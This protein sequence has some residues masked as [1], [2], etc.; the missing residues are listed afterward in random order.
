MT[1]KHPTQKQAKD[2]AAALSEVLSDLE[3][4]GQ[5]IP[6]RVRLAL[7]YAQEA[8]RAKYPARRSQLMGAALVHLSPSAAR[9]LLESEGQA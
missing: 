5:P 7:G 9:K 6:E 8:A 2:A 4:Q 3:K 1:P